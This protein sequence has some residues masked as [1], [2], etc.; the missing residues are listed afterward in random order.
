VQEGKG[1]TGPLPHRVP[2]FRKRPG[3]I[4]VNWTI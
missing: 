2:G 3:Q 1:K 4:S